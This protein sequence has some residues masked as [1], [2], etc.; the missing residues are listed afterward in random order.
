MP[1]GSDHI[2][3]EFHL[4]SPLTSMGNITLW[5]SSHWMM[6]SDSPGTLQSHSTLTETGVSQYS[7]SY[8]DYQT[9]SKKLKSLVPL[10][11]SQPSH[12]VGLTMSGLSK[13]STLLS[14]CLTGHSGL[15]TSLL[16]ACQVW[17]APLTFTDWLRTPLNLQARETRL[18]AQKL[19]KP[20]LERSGH[21]WSCCPVWRHQTDRN[22]PSSRQ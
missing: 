13:C 15:V 3:A 19:R 16:P 18:K 20:K 6:N 11:C 4:N 10:C 9:L 22:R 8:D 14:I 12:T 17:S 21:I 5:I 2:T 7:P 1:E